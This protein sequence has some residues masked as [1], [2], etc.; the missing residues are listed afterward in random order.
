[1]K[2]GLRDLEAD[3]RAQRLMKGR[4][5]DL[6]RM[7]PEQLASERADLHQALLRFEE[8]FGQPETA[9]EKEITRYDSLKKSDYCGVLFEKCFLSPTQGPLRPLQDRQEAREEI[10]RRECRQRHISEM[11]KF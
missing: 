4:P 8:S 1:M 6:E 5:S 7:A 10:Q 2:D 9:E 3:L 11:D